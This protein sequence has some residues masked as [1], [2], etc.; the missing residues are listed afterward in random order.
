MTAGLLHIFLF[1]TEKFVVFFFFF[2]RMVA[3]VAGD[4][5]GKGEGKTGRARNA[6]SEGEGKCL[7][8]AHCLFHLAPSLIYAN[9]CLPVKCQP[10]KILLTFRGNPERAKTMSG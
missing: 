8:P 1:N 9:C 4:R 6:R 3:C 10:M 7:Q 2:T 5:K